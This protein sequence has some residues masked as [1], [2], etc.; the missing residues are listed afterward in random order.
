[1]TKFDILRILLTN[2]DGEIGDLILGPS[3]SKLCDSANFA[4]LV[5]EIAFGDKTFA[6]RSPRA[7]S[8]AAWTFAA[9]VRRA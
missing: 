5:A 2:L 6:V 7:H 4:E 9:S 1:M 3:T 8:F